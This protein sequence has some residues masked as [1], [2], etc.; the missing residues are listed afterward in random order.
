M[1][2]V[3]GLSLCE[4]ETRTAA[5]S[6]SDP[7]P[8]QDLLFC[9]SSGPAWARVSGTG[10]SPATGALTL[11]PDA[12][13][14]GTFTITVRVIDG[15]TCENPTA[16]DEITISIAVRAAACDQPPPDACLGTATLRRYGGTGQCVEGA[17]VYPVT[18]TS[19]GECCYGAELNPTGNP[20]AGGAGYS[21]IID[22]AQAHS[23]VDDKAGLLSALAAASA[24][25]IIYI[26]DSA[27]IDLTGHQQITVPAGVTVASGRGRAGSEGALLR[28]GQFDSMPLF[29]AAGPG[30]RFTGL[31]LTGPDPEVGDHAYNTPKLS[32][33]IQTS[34][35]DLEVDN[36]ELQGFSHAAINLAQGATGAHIHHNYIHHNR[37]HGLGYGVVLDRSEALIEANLFDA[38]RHHIAATGRPSTSYEARFN[39]IL[40]LANGHYFDMHGAADFDKRISSAI[41]RF[42][43]GTGTSARDTSVYNSNHCTLKNM[44]SANCWVDGRIKKALR[45][46]GLDDYLDCGSHDTLKSAGGTVEFW[47]KAS[48]LGAHQDLVNIFEDGYQNYLLIRLH[49]TKAIYVRVEDDDQEKVNL[50]SEI[51]LN[52]ND[53][54]HVAVTQDGTSMKIYID[55]QESAV[56]GVNSDFWTAHLTL[57]GLWLGGGHWSHFKGLLDEVRLYNRALTA[58]EVLGHYQGHADIAGDSIKIH[59]NT[60]RGLDMYSVVIR[61]VPAQGGWIHHNWFHNGDP[62][63]A[64]RQTNAQGN[65]QVH[66]NHFGTATPPGTY[67]PTARAS[68]DPAYGREP[69]PLSFDGRASTDGAGPI[70]T[71]CWEFGDGQ[72][73]QGEQVSH[74]FTAPGRYQVL[75][76]AGNEKGATASRQLPVTVHPATDRNLLD[77]WVKDSYRGARANYYYKQALVDDQ[78]VWEDDVA[79]DEGWQHVSVDVGSLLAG[80]EQARLTFR[81]K[82]VTAVNNEEL[83]ELFVYF[84]DV[85]LFGGL[86]SNGEFETASGWSYAESGSSSWSG[87]ASSYDAHGGRRSYRITYPYKKDCPA[88]SHAQV[89]ALIPLKAAPLAHWLFDDGQGVQARDDSPNGLHGT[90]NNMEPGLAWV[91]G[92]V[93]KALLF[94][95]QDDYISIGGDPLLKSARGT[96]AFWMKTVLLGQNLDL[97]NIFQDSYQNYLLIRRN[98]ANRIYVRIE[99]GDQGKVALSSGE[100]LTSGAYHHI[101]V[102]Q[103]GSGVKIYIDGALS[104]ASGTNSSY[105]TDHLSLAGLWLGKGHWSHYGGI[106]D[107]VQL[108]G[109]ALSEEEIYLLAH[110][111]P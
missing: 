57:A 71:H 26:K 81:V 51:K 10:V 102:T 53:F 97:V 49:A 11:N 83:I 90:L 95:G 46:D 110:P 59:H 98:S 74:L 43:E 75:L 73:S 93:G 88:G 50:Y 70:A 92:K 41:W 108:H 96:L 72:R 85:H 48:L 58:E 76:T 68:A 61:G 28:T 84:D 16:H 6:A 107:E 63:R 9:L 100:V 4:G 111:G 89:S 2:E 1:S 91:A 67:L 35:P 77:F 17:C 47:L 14:A 80:K 12:G 29:L 40:H 106:L 94:D 32:R 44:D 15:G 8:G 36:C 22:P 42:D 82:N 101:A 20:I 86:L 13:T 103:D 25:E 3:G 104:G 62:A 21:R 24:G 5:L 27:V 19:C 7:D 54:H 64:V 55:G 18:D 23:V 33:G 31:R 79:G 34:H 78:V 60:F 52:D 109:R 30:I 38:C 66:T 39:I 99:E 37:R 56:T 45:F 69:L 65:L 87:G 105:W